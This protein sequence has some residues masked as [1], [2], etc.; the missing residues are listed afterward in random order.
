MKREEINFLGINNKKA[1]EYRCSYCNK[2]FFKGI[3]NDARIEIKCSN[4]KIMNILIS[5]KP[6]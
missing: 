4:C 5:K 3:L 2:L 6:I 1:K